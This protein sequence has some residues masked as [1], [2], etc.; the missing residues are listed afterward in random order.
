MLGRIT[1][2]LARLREVSKAS[3]GDAGRRVPANSERDCSLK[4]I[5]GLYPWD[6]ESQAIL[7]ESLSHDLLR[8][9]RSPIG[10]QIQPQKISDGAI[11]IGCTAIRA[12]IDATLRDCRTM[13]TVHQQPGVSFQSLATRDELM[14][15][16]LVEAGRWAALT[17]IS[18]IEITQAL[19]AVRESEARHQE[20]EA[21][22]VTPAAFAEE[23]VR[24]H[25]Q[26]RGS[27]QLT[28]PGPNP[29]R[30]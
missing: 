4:Q 1:T 30:P 24:S 2:S 6:L 25:R 18:E 10:P 13:A 29:R 11:A 8:A 12:L 5:K 3:S 26:G 28:N 14:K 21:F 22:K 9:L 20:A 17:G 27:N 23:T 19:E 7:L 15:T 16:A